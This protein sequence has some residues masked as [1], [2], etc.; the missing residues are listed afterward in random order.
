MKQN[1]NTLSEKALLILQLLH[2]TFAA[3]FNVLK[4]ALILAVS[5]GFHWPLNCKLK[6]E[7]QLLSES[8]HFVMG[9]TQCNVMPAFDRNYQAL[10][11]QS[12]LAVRHLLVC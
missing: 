3:E 6:G 8:G 1:T 10:K 5:F 7:Q 9:A 11:S 4:M 12:A 2:L